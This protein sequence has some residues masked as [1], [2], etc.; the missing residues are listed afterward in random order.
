MQII[1]LLKLANFSPH[2]FFLMYSECPLMRS[3][4]SVVQLF[5]SLWKLE[6]QLKGSVCL[7]TLFAW[8]KKAITI[9][10]VLFFSNGTKTDNPDPVNTW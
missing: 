10:N 2:F 9:K 1:L 3:I 7:Q 6:I 4:I 5:P 8:L